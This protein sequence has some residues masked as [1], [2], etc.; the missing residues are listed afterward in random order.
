MKGVLL[1]GGAG[2]RLKPMTEVT[3]KHLLPV[4]NKPMVFYPLQTLLDAGIKEILIV[5][6]KE[7]G[8]DFLELL[9]SGKRFGA[10]FTFKLQEEA[11]GIA[12]A[13]GLTERFVGTDKCTVILGDNIFEENFSKQVKLF[14]KNGKGAH[15][16]LKEVP[17]PQRFGVAE[18]GKEG[19]II[20]IEEKPKTPKSNFAVT[21][22]YMYDSDVFDV[23]KTLKPSW[24]GE[25]ELSDVNN[26]YVKEGKIE[27]TILNG[28]WSDAGTVESLFRATLFEEKRRNK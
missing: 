12:Q 13:L 18:I 15:V 2:T 24:R 4:Y 27:Y 20:K 14:D 10:D 21:G 17:D 16:F 8:G 9:G 11:G 7:H 22:I 28:F 23:I 5:T 19:K 26:H 3:N 6:G 25:L 1:A